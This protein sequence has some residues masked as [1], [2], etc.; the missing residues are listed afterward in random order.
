MDEVNCQASYSSW[1]VPGTEEDRVP[2]DK[3]GDSAVCSLSHLIIGYDY[4]NDL[5]IP[6]G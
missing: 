6:V 3:V 5:A 2:F 1:K 4:R